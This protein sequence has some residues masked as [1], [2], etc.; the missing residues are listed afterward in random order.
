MSRASEL[1]R[2]VRELEGPPPEAE[3][4]DTIIP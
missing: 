2:V 1:V 4:L 3:E